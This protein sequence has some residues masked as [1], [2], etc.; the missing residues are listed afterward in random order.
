[1]TLAA[2][3]LTLAL[4][5]AYIAAATLLFTVAT[6]LVS[7]WIAYSL[8]RCLRGGITITDALRH[9]RTPTRDLRRRARKDRN[10]AR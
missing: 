5:A 2:M 7:L 8:D 3:M 9:P 10:E 4:I 6:F 1:L